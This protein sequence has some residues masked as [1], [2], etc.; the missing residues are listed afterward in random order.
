[1][2]NELVDAFLKLLKLAVIAL[3]SIIVIIVSLFITL[4][5]IIVTAGLTAG[6]ILYFM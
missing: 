2:I 3:I 4:L 5:P 6:I 1:M